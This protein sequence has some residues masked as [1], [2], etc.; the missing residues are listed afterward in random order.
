MLD[1]VAVAVVAPSG[2]GKSTTAAALRARGAGWMTDDALALELARGQVLAHPGP[3]WAGDA[4]PVAESFEGAPPGPL[5][6][7]SVVLLR[8]EV[9]GGE[10]RLTVA[11]APVRLLLA[12]T[13]VPYVEGPVR[14][15]RLLA[16]ADAVARSVPVRILTA[17][18]EASPEMIAARIAAQSCSDARPPG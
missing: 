6:L 11:D 3:L 1:G 7:G 10:V 18:V 8:R 2:G 17:G 15:R 5:P 12:A 14:Q 13:F 4:G 9:A 16:V